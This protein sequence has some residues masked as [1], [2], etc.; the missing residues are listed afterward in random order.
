MQGN[1]TP[2]H[3]PVDPTLVK[4]L[5]IG[6]LVLLGLL[7]AWFALTAPA[8]PP[9]LDDQT[10]PGHTARQSG[11]GEQRLTLVDGRTVLCLFFPPPGNQISC[12][13]THAT[14]AQG[15]L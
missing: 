7:I 1:R 9:P 2:P 10:A 6:T 12:D 4:Q 11:V 14:T 8:P 5:T 13:W 15:A 3:H